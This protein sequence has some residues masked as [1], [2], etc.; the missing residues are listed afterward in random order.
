GFHH[1]AHGPTSRTIFQQASNFQNYINSTNIGLMNSAL[2]DLNSLKPG[3]TANITATVEKYGVNRTTLSK[4]WRGVQ[5]S[6]E[7]GYQNQQ[8]LTPQQEKTLVEWIEDLTA[9]GLPP[10][11]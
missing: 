9:Q 5:G 7:A 11:L 6:R 3:E 2:A 4:R 8:L 1:L 10:S